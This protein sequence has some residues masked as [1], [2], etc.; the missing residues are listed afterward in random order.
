MKFKYFIFLSTLFLASACVRHGHDLE[1]DQTKKGKLELK[2]DNV[3]GA[4][5]FA[6]STNYTNAVGETFKVDVFKYYISNLKL[7]TE[8]G[9]VYTVPQ[10]ES[11]F[12]I[13][14]S[15][16]TSQKIQIQIPEG[17]YSEVTFMVGVDSLRNTMDIS[18]RIGVLDTGAG[19][20]GM[21]WSWNSGYI[22]FKM[23]GSSTA[24]TAQNN[25]FMYHIGGFGG[26]SSGTANNTR[27]VTLLFGND[28]AK[29][30]A[31][32]DDSSVHILVD[33]LNVFAGTSNISI[34]TNATV[35]GTSL[36]SPAVSIANNYSR[37][38]RFDHVHGH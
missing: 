33:I 27:L 6:L 8:T 37:M 24:S 22:H 31:D 20:S 18:R 11:Y 28:R 26:Y 15:N 36:S 29:V 23:E 35:M 34:A 5:N 16:I 13:D 4:T 32:H 19:G 2:F 1:P 21:Y 14:E 38:F 25:A 30:R 17:N 7:K 12:L 3:A 9:M 10:D